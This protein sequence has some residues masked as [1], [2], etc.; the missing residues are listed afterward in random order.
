MSVTIEHDMSWDELLRA[1]LDVDAPEGWRAELIDGEI[2]MTPPPTGRHNRITALVNGHLTPAVPPGYGVFQTLGVTV[3]TAAGGY[4]PDLCVVPYGQVPDEDGYVTSEVV[5]LAV[6]VT[7]KR[8]ADHDRKKKRWGY[9]HGGVP[10]Y[11]L[12]DR[13]DDEGPTVSLLSDPLR[14]QYRNVLRI[15]IGEPVTLPA[16]FGIELPTDQF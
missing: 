6:E 8:Y 5:V 10:L 9:A 14:G 7:S 15:P 2:V 11:L 1:W 12:I 4:V 13:F 3:P 16:P